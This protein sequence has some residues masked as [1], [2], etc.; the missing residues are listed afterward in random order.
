MLPVPAESRNESIRAVN[1]RYT[2][3]YKAMP[4]SISPRSIVESLL[5]VRTGKKSLLNEGH[6]PTQDKNSP[7]GSLGW[8]S[9]V[10][11]VPLCP[12][13]CEG[14]SALYPDLVKR[15]IDPTL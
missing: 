6:L 10:V 3:V 5:P 13:S 8:K 2:V 1:G 4:G 7:M 11:T 9:T 12:G 15:E 14:S